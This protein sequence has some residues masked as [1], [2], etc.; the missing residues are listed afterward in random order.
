MS[1]PQRMAHIKLEDKTGKW[2]ATL[3]RTGVDM[4]AWPKV[5]IIGGRVF[6]IMRAIRNSAT[7]REVSH[8]VIEGIPLNA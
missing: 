4:L 5:M 7:Y 3:N 2:L 1:V 6:H 8:V